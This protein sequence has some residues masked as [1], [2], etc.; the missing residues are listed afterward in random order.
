VDKLSG[1]VQAAGRVLGEA[2]ERLDAIKS[3]I[4]ASENADQA[5]LQEL[6][7]L[8]VKLNDLRRDLYGD[9]IASSRMY[10]ESPSINSRIGAVRGDQWG[11]TSPPTQ[12]HRDQYRYAGEAF[13]VFLDS[14]R[15]IVQTDLPS[16]EQRLDEAGAPWTPTRFPEWHDTGDG[17]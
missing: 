7:A 9:R 12:T 15:P 1:A 13:T 16:L 14:L 2:Q 6:H 8:Q 10:P 4:V 11:V 5:M 3:A 17:S